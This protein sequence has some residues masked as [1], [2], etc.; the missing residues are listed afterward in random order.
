MMKQRGTVLI[1][2][3][4]AHEGLKEQMA[5]STAM[6]ANVRAKAEKA[7]ACIAETVRKAVKMG[8]TIALGTDAGVYPHG[9][10]PK[11][12]AVMVRLGMTPLQAIRSATLDAGEL[13]G[14]KDR[15]G[16]LEPGKLA[17]LIGV[18]GDPLSDVHVLESVGFVMKGGVV[19]KDELRTSG[20][21][22]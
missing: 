17:D 18:R 1:P 20:A 7:G 10:N 14:W 22:G 8:V 19:V 9:N 16:S 15:V 5:K 21:G 11:Q 4:M 3:L 13:L 12:F 2:T 6:P